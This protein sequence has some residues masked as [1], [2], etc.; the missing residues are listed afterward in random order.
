MVEHLDTNVDLLLAK[1]D[2]M[3]LGIRRSRQVK[4]FDRLSDVTPTL[5]IAD[6]E[7]DIRMVLP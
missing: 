2:A 4:C 7:G 3:K 1:L 5:V 6:N